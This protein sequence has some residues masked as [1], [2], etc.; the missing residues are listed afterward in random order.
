MTWFLNLCGESGLGKLRRQFFAT[1]VRWCNGSTE[2]FGGF[3]HGSNPCRTTTF[4]NENEGFLDSRTIPAQNPQESE[5]PKMRFP[6]IIRH[7]KAEVTIYGKKRI[8]HSTE[9]FTGWPVNARWSI[10]QSIRMLK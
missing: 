4:I 2:L 3:S 7:K 6:R 9:S 8:I 5:T 10:L 1:P